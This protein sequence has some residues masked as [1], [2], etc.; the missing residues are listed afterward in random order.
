MCS[1]RS[2][3]A[4]SNLFGQLIF[5]DTD[6]KASHLLWALS[7]SVFKVEAQPEFSMAKEKVKL[8]LKEVSIKN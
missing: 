3:P 2:R 6:E 5:E 7:F 8:S 1:V 4:E